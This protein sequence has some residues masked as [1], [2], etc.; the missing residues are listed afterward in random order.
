[1][2][3][4]ILFITQSLARTGSEVLLWY[5]LGTLDPAKYEIFVFCSNKGEL[6][7]LLPEY[8][9]KNVRYKNS[10]IF[11]ERVLRRVVRFLGQ[12]PLSYQ[13]NSIHKKFKPDIWYIN[14]IALSDVYEAGKV[15]NVKM[16]T[17]IHELLNAFTLISRDGL[18]KIISHSATCIACSEIVSETLINL[19]HPDVRLQYSFVDTDAIAT[20]A[21]KISHIKHDLGILPE[22][23][24]WVLAGGATY[25]KGLDRVLPIL[26]YF[27][28]TTIKILWLGAQ[29]DSGLDFYVKT[30]ADLKY[31]GRLI[32][33]GVQ[34]EDYY[35]YL[36]V[37]NGFL[38]LSR[39][40]SFSMVM[41][42]A[43]W[44]GV[45]VVAFD[46]GI[47][48]RFI[49]RDMGFVVNE[50]A[51]KEFISCMQTV[52]TNPNTIDRAALRQAAENYSLKQQLPKFEAL[53][54]ELCN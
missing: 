12:D 36:S 10:P 35:N 41:V 30:V 42:E 18:S 32:F 1:M 23:F 48:Q 52:Q 31:P 4:R 53:L 27:K 9:Q 24:V 38:L 7:D 54:A 5:L 16:V 3:K 51:L 34:G 26:E 17:H 44:L 20:D 47:A 46:V 25:M 43:A 49:S 14:T 28:D 39:E 50:G 33:G 6:Y 29:F 13:L 11:L 45:P 40:E 19:G 8:V 22:D 21:T 37:A 15:L 2:K